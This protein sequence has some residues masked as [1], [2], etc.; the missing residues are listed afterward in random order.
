M[1]GT[2]PGTEALS[3]AGP[4]VVETCAN[5]G[6]ASPENLLLLDAS[7]AGDEVSPRDPPE[8][9]VSTEHTNNRIGESACSWGC[10]VAG[11]ALQGRHVDALAPEASMVLPGCRL[12]WAEQ[13]ECASASAAVGRLV[14]SEARVQSTAPCARIKEQAKPLPDST[15]GDRRKHSGNLRMQP[16]I[17]SLAP[18]AIR[19]PHPPDSAVYFPDILC[20]QPLCGSCPPPARK[21]A[22][23]SPYQ[24]S[25]ALDP[26]PGF[27]CRA[28]H[29][30]HILAQRCA[31][32]GGRPSVGVQRGL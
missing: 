4:Q 30:V 32:G 15:R 14:A 2:E 5:V 3:V 7:P 18:A 27:P 29:C 25:W 17:P 6:A 28:G 22:L 23:P 9:R 19:F 13:Q 10:G 26:D 12:C 16:K 24:C 20:S 8:P 11:G 1:P 21:P 31:G